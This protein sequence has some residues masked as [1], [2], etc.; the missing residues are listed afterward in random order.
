MEC[1][2]SSTHWD[3]IFWTDVASGWVG[4]KAPTH[5]TLFVL[6]EMHYIS[7]KVGS[8]R[9]NVATALSHC[10]TMIFSAMCHGCWIAVCPHGLLL[11]FAPLIVWP[12]GVKNHAYYVMFLLSSFIGNLVFS[13]FVW[14]RKSLRQFINLF[15][16]WKKTLDI[17]WKDIPL[18]S[19]SCLQPHI[20]CKLLSTDSLLY[21][22]THW[23]MLELVF[24]GE[25]MIKLAWT[26]R[27]NALPL[28]ISSLWK[29]FI[30]TIIARLFA[31]NR[32]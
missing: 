11:S 16:L 1:M 15:C 23:T 25:A 17:V 3:T 19:S 13:Y 28:H 31:E 26:C 4:C 7:P 14:T 2:V 8:V 6:Q 32:S 29:G 24:V 21:W 12:V 9:E 30:K 27:D 5:Q 22:L 18:P 20:F 10:L